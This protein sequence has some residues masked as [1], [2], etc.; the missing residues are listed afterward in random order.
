[1]YENFGNFL[2]II[3][4]KK[5]DFYDKKNDFRPETGISSETTIPGISSEMTETRMIALVL[6][7]VT[8][9]KPSVQPE[10]SV[11]PESPVPPEGSRVSDG[12]LAAPGFPSSHSRFPESSSH[13]RFPFPA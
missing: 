4:T 8:G 1:M 10:T 13:S 5:I 11:P 3:S 12:S 6:L 2:L 9:Q 7:L